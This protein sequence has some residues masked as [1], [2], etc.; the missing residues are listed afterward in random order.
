MGLS[1]R[2][3]GNPTGGT[4]NISVTRSIP[5]WTGEPRSASS[6]P[7]S[8]PVYPR[9]DGGTLEGGQKSLRI[10]GLS[11]R[12]RGNLIGRHGW[13]GRKRSI[14]AW[15]GEP[16]S[17][18]P[19]CEVLAVYPRVD[20]GTPTDITSSQCCW[21]LSPRGRGNLVD[22]VPAV[23]EPGSIPAWTGEPAPAAAGPRRRPVYPRVDGGTVCEARRQDRPARHRSIP[24]WTGEPYAAGAKINKLRVYPRVDGG[25]LRRAA[26]AADGEGLSPRGRGNPPNGW[27]SKC[28]RRSIPAWTGEPVMHGSLPVSLTVYP[29]V[30]GGTE[31]WDA[32][33]ARM[34]GL[35]PR[36]RGEPR[37]G[38]GFGRWPGVYPRVDGGT[39]T[40]NVTANSIKGLS[41]RGRG[42]RFVSQ[43][44]SDRMRSIPAWTGEPRLSLPF[45]KANGVY[46]RVDGG[47]S[48][49]WQVPKATSVYPRVDGEPTQTGSC[50]R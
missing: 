9:V 40:S 47:T 46:P 8:S 31:R 39:L 25:T 22:G 50:R 37:G 33:E 44:N 11:P 38:Y 30:D 26:A 29:R 43:P 1:P 10:Q 21:G 34:S 4:D 15:T 13:L 14:P 20:G 6:G 35:S 18:S 49:S 28:R 7:R 27:S 41:P 17:T 2:G 19:E 48:T 45:P 36:G 16:P 32:E 23:D 5:A 12:G 24:A 42:N 3:R